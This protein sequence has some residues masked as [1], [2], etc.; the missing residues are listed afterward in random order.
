VFN[1]PDLGGYLSASEVKEIVE[2][3][4]SPLPLPG[5]GV[6]G[7]PLDPGDIWLVGILACV[8]E[9]SI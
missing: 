2:A 5:A 7:T 6:E 3:V 1:L 9:I 4:I 8:N